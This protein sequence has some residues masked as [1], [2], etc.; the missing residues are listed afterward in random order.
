MDERTFWELLFT[1]PA[2][3]LPLLMSV[4]A[5][6]GWG[7]LASQEP[8]ARPLGRAFLL[9]S[10]V[11]GAVIVALHEG[12]KDRMA[13]EREVVSVE[14]LGEVRRVRRATAETFLVDAGGRVLTLEG[15]PGDLRAGEA[16]TR[17]LRGNA[18][19]AVCR[20][21]QAQPRCWWQVLT[22]AEAAATGAVSPPKE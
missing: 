11:V 2:V 8:A 20:A 10:A 14:P 7:A 21:E 17:E 15:R 16:M 13:L 12:S 18:R 5:L 1:S 4:T 6:L 19:L 3:F 22:A 9:C